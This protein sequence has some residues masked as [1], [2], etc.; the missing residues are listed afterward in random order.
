MKVE[1][2]ANYK[3]ITLEC[4]VNYKQAT[5]D[6]D[7]LCAICNITED[8][9][10]AIPVSEATDIIQ[11][12]E[13]TLQYESADFQRTIYV[14][15]Q[16][17]GFIPNLKKMSLAEYVDISAFAKDIH[18]HA[19]SLMAIFYRPITHK[20]GNKY[21][22]EDYESKKRELNEELV[23]TMSLEQLNGALLFFSTLTRDFKKTSLEF[24]EETLSEMQ[25]ANA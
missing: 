16:E 23:K 4:F 14:G 2:P 11:L 15:S 1:V 10:K 21:L 9:A 5:N 8:E 24:L 19:I 18:K 6:Y 7:R 13:D 20:V 12:F 22:C 25:K 17:F 3:G